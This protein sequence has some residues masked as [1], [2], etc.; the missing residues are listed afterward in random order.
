MKTAVKKAVVKW[1][2]GLVGILVIASALQFLVWSSR[3]ELV[4]HMLAMISGPIDADYEAIEAGLNERLGFD[5]FFIPDLWPF[6][7]TS[8]WR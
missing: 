7:N 2:F 4:D 6:D 1:L 3:E 5:R 8:I